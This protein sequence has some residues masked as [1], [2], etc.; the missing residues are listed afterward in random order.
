MIY[1]IYQGILNN[2]IRWYY[3]TSRE[4]SEQLIN[5]IIGMD[6]QYLNERVIQNR[7]PELDAVITGT[8]CNLFRKQCMRYYYRMQHPK[9]IATQHW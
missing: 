8:K 5:R 9:I 4:D 3:T 6:W 2:K 1:S 7:I